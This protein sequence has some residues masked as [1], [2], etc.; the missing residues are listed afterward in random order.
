[1]EHVKHP[2]HKYVHIQTNNLLT[3]TFTYFVYYVI[4][5]KMYRNNNCVMCTNNI[6][7]LQNYSSWNLSCKTN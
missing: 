6:I 4:I 3:F 5:M 1:M 7:L 2:V